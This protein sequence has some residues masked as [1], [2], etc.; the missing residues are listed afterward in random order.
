MTEYKIFRWDA[1]MSNNGIVKAPMIY[2]KPDI[3]FL[4]FARSNNFAVAC[5]IS[6]TGTIYDG[7]IIS[8][9]V[10]KSYYIPNCRPNFYEKTGFYVVTLWSNWYGYPDP[11]KMGMVKFSGMKNVQDDSYNQSK[12]P[13][14]PQKA[15]H[16]LSDSKTNNSDNKIIIISGV[17]VFFLVML[18]ILD[19]ILR[20]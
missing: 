3:M 2:I 12:S 17:I 5:E 10:D 20:S 13:V 9:T 11:E 16:K 7:K 14:L 19:K 6:G 1:V 15:L 8:G 4:E 18:F